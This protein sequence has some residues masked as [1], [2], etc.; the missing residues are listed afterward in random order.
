VLPEL[1][2]MAVL[3]KHLLFQVRQLHILVVE[4]VLVIKE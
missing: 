4:V 1:V 2:A 3:D